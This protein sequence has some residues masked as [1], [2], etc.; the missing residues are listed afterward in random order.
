MIIKQTIEPKYAKQKTLI[1]VIIAVYNGIETLQRCISSILSQTYSHKELI[2]MD[3]GSTD[4]SVEILKFYGDE[5]TYYESKNDRGI[6]HAWNKA[7]KHANGEWICFLG[8]DDYFW[9][10]TVLNDLLP[11][12]LKAAKD[13]IK[14]VYGQAVKVNIEGKIIKLVG[15]PWDKIQWLMY[16]G[17]P[18]IHAGIMHHRSLFE[19]HGFF[20]ETF[21]I[22]GDYDF[23]LRELKH[24]KALFAEGVRTVCHQ[25]GGISDSMNLLTNKEI[26]IARRKNGLNAFSLI[27]TVVYLRA[28]LRNLW[29]QVRSN[30]LSSIN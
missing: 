27:W 26:A 25:K 30:R 20:D 9:S 14:I 13:D 5:I 4:G 8:A 28:L 12:L 22:A 17:M 6:Y 10:N 1:T 11:F 23:L 29:R 2:I 16:H 19:L 3:G 24:G 15:K 18:L 21:K 7:L